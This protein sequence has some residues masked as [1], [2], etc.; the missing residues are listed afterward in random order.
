MK[1]QRSHG[2]PD[3]GMLHTVPRAVIV[4]TL[5]SIVWAFVGSQAIGGEAFPL[6]MALTL[7]TSLLLLYL[8]SRVLKRAAGVPVTQPVNPFRI[9]AYRY[10]VIFEALLIPG[11]IILFNRLGEVALITPAISVIVGLHFFGLA[12][13]FRA[14]GS[15]A[16]S[17][18]LAV[19]TAMILLPVL[20]VLFLPAYVGG[21]AL[22]LAHP[23]AVWT[24][25]VGLGCALI[26][27]L[28]AWFNL[29]RV[30]RLAQSLI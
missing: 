14:K 2:A 18:Y 19:G 17:A 22:G 9:P 4:I 24:A 28:D 29:A 15:R 16:S 10:S 30:R 3:P 12:I 11:A 8:A 5:F 27:W 23:I 1:D 26:L 13:A 7:L 21:G 20:A 6:L 25:F